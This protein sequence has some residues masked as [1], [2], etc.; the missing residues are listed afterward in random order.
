MNEQKVIVVLT[1]PQPFFSSD[2]QREEKSHVADGNYTH[3]MYRFI[4]GLSNANN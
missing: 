3:Q 2:I 1:S 4:S